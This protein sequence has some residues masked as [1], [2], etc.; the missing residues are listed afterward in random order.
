MTQDAD[1]GVGHPLWSLDRRMSVQGP[2]LQDEEY[3][4]CLLCCE[5]F[6]VVLLVEHSN[7]HCMISRC[8]VDLGSGFWQVRSQGDLR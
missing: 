3:P 7:H 6:K 1:K 4:S 2:L 5:S 8:P